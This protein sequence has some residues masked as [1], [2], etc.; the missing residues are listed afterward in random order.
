VYRC[1]CISDI[2]F[3]KCWNIIRVYGPYSARPKTTKNPKILD[4][5]ANIA[6]QRERG[7]RPPKY[8]R[9]RSKS[10]IF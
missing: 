3:Q 7:A 5:N 4:K 8:A 1:V 6:G 9:A 2:Q 10:T